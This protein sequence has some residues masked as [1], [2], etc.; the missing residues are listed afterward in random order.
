MDFK[1]KDQQTAEKFESVFGVDKHITIPGKY[2]GK[3]SDISPEIAKS[4]IDMGDNQVKAKGSGSTAASGSS[5][6]SAPASNG[7]TGK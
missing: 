7:N 1:F 6:T 2:S 4:L 5:S 3:L